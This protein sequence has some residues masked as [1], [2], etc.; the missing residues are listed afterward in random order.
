MPNAS[1]RRR[2]GKAQGE[3]YLPSG[4][5]RR[6]SEA[7]VCTSAA[8]KTVGKPLALRQGRALSEVW[9]PYSCASAHTTFRV[10]LRQEQAAEEGGGRRASGWRQARSATP[11]STGNGYRKHQAL[12]REPRST[13]FRIDGGLNVVCRKGLLTEITL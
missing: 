10:A 5:K 9:F 3:G 8:R 7:K 1:W 6:T 2:G 12:Q 4:A 13:M 11:P